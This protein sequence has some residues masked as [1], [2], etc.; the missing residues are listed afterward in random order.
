MD[1]GYRAS[2]ELG[3]LLMASDQ[4]NM[5]TATCR[6]ILMHYSSH[7]LADARPL[8]FDVGQMPLFLFV[9]RAELNF[10]RLAIDRQFHFSVN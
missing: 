5:Q 2:Y 4:L 8:Q 7:S 10:A 6:A 3:L 1:A 9:A